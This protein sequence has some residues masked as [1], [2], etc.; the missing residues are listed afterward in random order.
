VSHDPEPHG[1]VEIVH[2]NWLAPHVSILG[3]PKRQQDI[4][5][6]LCGSATI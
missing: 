4:I 3:Q 1:R 2:R 5:V 6:P